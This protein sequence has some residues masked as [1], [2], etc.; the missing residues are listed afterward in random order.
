[1]R[2]QR[3]DRYDG[4]TTLGI[5]VSAHQGEIDWPQ[6]ARAHATLDGRPQGRPLYAVVRTSDGVQTRRGSAPDPLAVRNLTGAHHAGLLVA[7]YHYVRA[8]HPPEAQVELVLDIVRKAGVPPGFIALDI[9]GRPDDLDTGA[10]ES[11]GAWWAPSGADERVQTVHVLECLHGMA[12]LLERAG[13]RV[14]I[15]TAQSWHWYVSQSGLTPPWCRWPLWCPDY[16]HGPSPRLPVDATGRPAPWP[17][18]LI[19]Q[20]TSEG[21]IA[22]VSGPV[23]LNRFRGDESACRGW[24][25]R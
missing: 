13:Q 22:G 7:G 4:P 11:A 16:V 9:E 18:A 20:Y 25:G 12:D 19:W 24:W 1:M 5:D 3:L 2:R 21:H 10:D 8:F 23:D 14:V 6:V 17:S 15:Y